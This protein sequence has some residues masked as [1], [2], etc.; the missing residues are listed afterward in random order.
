[1][2]HMFVSL[3]YNADLAYAFHAQTPAKKKKIK[4]QINLIDKISGYVNFVGTFVKWQKKKEPYSYFSFTCTHKW[5]ES[6]GN[7]GS[8]EHPQTTWLTPPVGF[9]NVPKGQRPQT[10]AASRRQWRKWDI[11]LS[12]H[13]SHSLFYWLHKSLF[14]CW[15]LLLPGKLRTACC[16]NPNLSVLSH[17]FSSS[18]RC[19]AGGAD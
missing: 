14:H 8:K 12:S 4:E 6:W 3:L 13:T 16:F 19:L 7:F 1:M 9:H 15:L 5:T 17:H 2:S 11:R 10:T 18:S